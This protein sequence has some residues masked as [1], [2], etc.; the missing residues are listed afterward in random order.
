MQA[1]VRAKHLQQQL[2]QQQKALSTKGKEGSKLK[3][4]VEQGQAKV[5]ACIQ[6]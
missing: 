3:Q 2:A 6:R 5:D 1:D 4:E